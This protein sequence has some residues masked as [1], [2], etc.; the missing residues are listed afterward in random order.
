M[1]KGGAKKVILVLNAGSSS[2]KFKLFESG[3]LKEIA[4]GLVERIGLID[5]FF[6]YQD[7]GDKATVDYPKGVKTIRGALEI[8]LGK[9]SLD[10]VQI[11]GV[12]HRVVH[13]GEKYY[14][15]VK[16][17]PAILKELEKL[18]ELAPLHNPA[19]IEGIKN[20]MRILKTVPDIAVF[21][22]GFHHT[23]PEVAYTYAIP[24]GLARKFKI[25]RYGFHGISHEYV[26]KEA[27]R[28]LKKPFNQ[29]NL[30]TCHLGNGCSISAVKKGKS[31]ENSMGFTPLEGLV[32]GTRSGDIDPAIPI[33]LASQGIKTAEIDRLLNKSSGLLGLSSLS[34]D[35][36]DILTAAGYKVPGFAGKKYSIQRKKQAELA[37]NVFIY[38]I[39]KYI[40]AYA[41]VLG[42]VDAVV[43]TGGMGERNRVVRGLIKKSV[44]PFVKARFLAIPTNEELLI[45]EKVKEI[46]K[47]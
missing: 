15:P 45:A 34:S 9:I 3:K 6:E 2:L 25:R 31:I 41:C 22:T 28:K 19:N 36:R 30:I 21:D 39:Q 33:F 27:A 44:Y 11:I 5:S 38:R 18:S 46:L 4:S 20:S 42:Q 14:R 1:T 12:G 37:L 40:G 24:A 29:V 32:M 35:M 7:Q 47:K 17:T 13:G 26:A 43:L 23:I 8:V 10:N 16:I